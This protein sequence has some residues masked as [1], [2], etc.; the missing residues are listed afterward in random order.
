MSEPRRIEL[1][2]EVP[3]TP[4]QVWAA[5]ATGEGLSSWFVPARVDER[6]GGTVDMDFGD[7]GT[8][9]ARVTAWEPPHRFVY[10]GDGDRALAFE[11]LV[12][13]GD[14]GSC[15]VRLVSSGFGDGADWDAEY[16]GMDE[17]WQIFLEVLRLHLVHFPDRPA[18]TA[19][20]PTVVLTG[21][22]ATAW[23]RLCDTLGVPAD[24]VAGDRIATGGGTDDG[25]PALAGTV[26]SRLDTER[27]TAYVLL[28][29]E[30][31]PG[32]AFLAVEGA[33]DQPAAST[34]LY[35]RGPV[36]EAVAPA[37][38]AFLTG[39]AAPGADEAVA[40]SGAE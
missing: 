14:G 24:L 33:G 11:W 5:I 26:A 2:V 39:L 36:D 13:A 22:G 32:T 18:T 27:T 3:G 6:A 20:V 8:E 7:L 21:P 19:V 40:S 31:A 37:W 29:D 34:W 12:E 35:L 9:Q 16:D 4:E 1:S 10:E 15:V 38:S 30:P 17:G 25:V 28:L 23:S